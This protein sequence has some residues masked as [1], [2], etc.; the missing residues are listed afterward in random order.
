MPVQY[1]KKKN[2]LINILLHTLMVRLE[3]QHIS[4]AGRQFSCHPLKALDGAERRIE[5]IKGMHLV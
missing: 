5:K 2:V 1:E 4:M 3:Q